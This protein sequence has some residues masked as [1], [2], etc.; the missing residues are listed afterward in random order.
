MDSS[1][2]H[3]IPSG[4]LVTQTLRSALASICTDEWTWTEVNANGSCSPSL[5]FAGRRA[6]SA[7]DGWQIA[8]LVPQL[9]RGRLIIRE[10]VQAAPIPMRAQTDERSEKRN[11]QTLPP[12]R[13][14]LPD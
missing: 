7:R 11:A 8:Q 1:D 3:C 10:A 2:E 13:R 4:L 6:R 14:T 12:A 9:R 5:D